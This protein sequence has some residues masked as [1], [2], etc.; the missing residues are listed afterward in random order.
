MLDVVIGRAAPLRVENNAIV[1]RIGYKNI[2]VNLG[3]A[4]KAIQIS[5]TWCPFISARSAQ[6]I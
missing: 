4:S 2:P 5:G 6:R 3:G 1:I